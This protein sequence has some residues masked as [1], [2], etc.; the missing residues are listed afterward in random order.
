MSKHIT[1]PAISI[2]K[3]SKKLLL[4]SAGALVILA[5]FTVGVVNQVKAERQNRA[6][7]TQQ[8]AKQA[9]QERQYKVRI[10]SLEAAVA[11]SGKA[12]E[13]N[14]AICEWVRGVQAQRR[15][16]V[17]PLCVASKI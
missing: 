7:A 13:D 14:K 5:V 12:A 15:Q 8:A 1:F 9:E 16:P 2:P 17:P 10:S 6:V 4:I 3:V 11:A